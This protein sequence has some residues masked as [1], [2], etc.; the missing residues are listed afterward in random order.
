LRFLI[1]N[2]LPKSLCGFFR[3]RGFD[4]QHALHVG[5]DQASDAEIGRYALESAR[6]V[7]TK[8][9]HFLYLANRP[10]HGAVSS[11]FASAIVGPDHCSGAGKREKITYTPHLQVKMWRTRVL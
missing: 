6:I 7:T 1:D 3:S 5:M 11:G 10:G 4:C 8:E 2:Q 9:E